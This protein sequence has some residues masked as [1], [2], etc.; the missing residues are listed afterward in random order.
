V[1]DTCGIKEIES[2][3]LPEDKISHVKERKRLLQGKG[4]MIGDGINDGPALANAHVGVA[5]G[6]AGTQLAVETADVILLDS[7]LLRLPFL[8]KLGRK[9]R[10]TI[11]FNIFFS[12]SIKLVLIALIFSTVVGNQMWVAIVADVGTM[13]LVT[14]NGMRLLRVKNNLRLVRKERQPCCMPFRAKRGCE[15]VKPCCRK[16]LDVPKKPCCKKED[17]DVPTKPCCKKDDDV[18]KKPCCKKDDDVPKK[19][20][21]K[22]DDDVPKKPC[23]KKDDDVP[24]KPCCKKDD[25]V[26]PKPCC[27]KDQDVPPKPCC[28]KDHVV[29]PKLCCSPKHDHGSGHAHEHAHRSRAI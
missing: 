3:L 14:L 11:I 19:P 23:C 7:N 27:K 1:G 21:C 10:H 5:M 20:C 8:V 2:Q 18:P 13:L 15:D 26:P 29:S 16:N 6:A 22:K 4:A 24:K 28:K 9:T 25:D 12:V 17:D